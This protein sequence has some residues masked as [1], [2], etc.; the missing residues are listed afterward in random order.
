MESV[1]RDGLYTMLG[2][3]TNVTNEEGW[4]AEK[5]QGKVSPVTEDSLGVFS[6]K[7]GYQVENLKQEELWMIDGTNRLS[8]G[9]KE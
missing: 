9:N 7:W 2:L 6:S 1:K 4:A 3:A 5:I 8:K